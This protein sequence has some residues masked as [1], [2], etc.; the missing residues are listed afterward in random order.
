MA[1][2]KRERERERERDTERGRGGV[3]VY[4]SVCMFACVRVRMDVCSYACVRGEI[5]RKREG[6]PWVAVP[7]EGRG[8]S[9]R[10]VADIKAEREKA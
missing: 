7:Q 10:T 2:T 9:T 6:A 1:A 3:H 5:E 8:T 4:V